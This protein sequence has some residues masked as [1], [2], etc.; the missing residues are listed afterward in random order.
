[1]APERASLT[2]GKRQQKHPAKR[3]KE[4]PRRPVRPLLLD[5]VVLWEIGL[6]AQRGLLE[7]GDSFDGFMRRLESMDG[8]SIHPVDLAIWRQVLALDWDH[9]D[10]A[11]RI[12]VATAMRHDATLLSSDQVIRAFFSEAVW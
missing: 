1:M 4:T 8:V 12:I 11:D 2:Y 9:R 7:L 5:T 10:P 3:V 6:K